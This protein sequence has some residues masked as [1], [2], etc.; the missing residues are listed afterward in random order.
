MLI[1]CDRPGEGT[2]AEECTQNGETLNQFPAQASCEKLLFRFD[3]DKM[4]E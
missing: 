4:I 3:C 1:L 2:L